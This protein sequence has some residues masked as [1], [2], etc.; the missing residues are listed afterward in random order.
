LKLKPENKNK[1]IAIFVGCA[2]AYRLHKLFPKVFTHMETTYTEEVIKEHNMNS[3]LA[4]DIM[5]EYQ[6]LF[7]AIL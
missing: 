3:L 7:K 6:L 4:E 1:D 2:H 5:T